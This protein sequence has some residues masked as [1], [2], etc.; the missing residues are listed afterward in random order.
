M[1]GSLGQSGDLQQTGLVGDGGIA[2]S[3]RLLRCARCGALVLICRACD[4][5][6]RYCG[7]ACSTAARK[8]AQ[9]EAAQRYQR[10]PA[11][12]AAHASRSQRWRDRRR[13]ADGDL[14]AVTHQG[15]T[16]MLE[17]AVG[18]PQQA[19]QVTPQPHDPHPLLLRCM[20]CAHGLGPWLRC[21][22]LRRPRSPRPRRRTPPSAL[23][24]G[25]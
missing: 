7:R 20:C 5:G 18:V 1:T 9:Q 3:A 8:Q 6:Q 21:G 15:G 10:S 16:A 22:A 19:A 24:A 17:E 13:L 23:S 11:G 25:P 14:P 12:R 2:S 4:R